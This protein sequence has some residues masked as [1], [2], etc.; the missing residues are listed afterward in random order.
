MFKGSITAL[1]TP[2]SED[3]AFDQATFERFVD[4]QITEGSHGLV[5]VGTTGESPTLS[6][7]EH[8]QVVETCVKT[9]AGRVPVIAGAG[10]NSTREAVDL[11]RHAEDVG[12]DAVLVVC[13]YYNKPSQ[14]GLF[15]HF[16][17]VHDAISLPVIIYNIPGRSVVDMGV[18]TMARLAELPRIAGVKDATGDLAR[19]ADQR[20]AAGP[21]FIQ[22]SGE[23][24]T[25]LGFMAMGGHGTISVTSNVAPRLCADFQNACM[26]GD[27]TTA[28][29]LQDRL[30][31][32]HKAMFVEPS[33]AGAKYAAELLGLCRRDVRLPMLP[34]S[35]VGQA[36]VAGAVASAG[37]MPASWG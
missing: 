16:Q 12:A 14:D 34:L 33:P 28:L 18:D 5:P 17:A 36:V 1:I 11:A 26:A 3:G 7:T 13:P 6:H 30:L 2:F 24:A 23:D 9:A 4:W 37:L 35:E 19:C 15:Y 10:S 20:A 22:L 8:R 32:L 31:G 25:A 29:A 21:D 27:Y